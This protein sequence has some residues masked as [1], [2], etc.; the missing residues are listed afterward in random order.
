MFPSSSGEELPQEGSIRIHRAS[1]SLKTPTRACD[2][3]EGTSNRRDSQSAQG[4]RKKRGGE[5]GDHRVLHTIAIVASESAA[6]FVV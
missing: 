5:G 3:A 4:R 1:G 2:Y 6:G